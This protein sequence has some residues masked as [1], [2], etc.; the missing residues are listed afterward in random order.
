MSKNFVPW[1]VAVRS[2]EYYINKGSIEK[3]DNAKFR[4]V[5]LVSDLFNKGH[6]DGFIKVYFPACDDDRSVMVWCPKLKLIVGDFY[7]NPFELPPIIVP[8]RE[9]VN[10]DYRHENLCYCLAVS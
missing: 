9:L 10:A 7:N 2:P 3:K 1:E 4:T 8:K 6:R 5:K